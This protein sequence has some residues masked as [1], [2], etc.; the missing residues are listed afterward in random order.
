MLRTG[1]ILRE[2]HNVVISRNMG[3]I[4]TFFGLELD[5]HFAEYQ[6]DSSCDA[7]P[8]EVVILVDPSN[9]TV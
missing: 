7:T 9:D 3:V 8:V 6:N 1:V 5:W 4:G 2:I